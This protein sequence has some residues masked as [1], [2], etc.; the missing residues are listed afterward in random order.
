ML[1]NSFLHDAYHMAIYFS[2]LL[3]PSSPPQHINKVSRGRVEAPRCARHIIA[4]LMNY[5]GTQRAGIVSDEAHFM[6]ASDAING[7]DDIGIERS[8]RRYTH[9]TLA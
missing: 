1:A 8:S 2:S 5:Y 7:Q 3:A 9:D 6:P 4:A